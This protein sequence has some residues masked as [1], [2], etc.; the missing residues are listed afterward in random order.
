MLTCAL[1]DYGDEVI[2]LVKWN[3]P[4][5]L[6]TFDFLGDARKGKSAVATLPDPGAFDHSFLV[7]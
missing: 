2:N 4:R 7:S 6:V 1:K 5:T 3:N